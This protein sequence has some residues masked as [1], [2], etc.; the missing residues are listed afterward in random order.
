MRQLLAH[1]AVGKRTKNNP[2]PPFKVAKVKSETTTLQEM[3][4]KLVDKNASSELKFLSLIVDSMSCI[5]DLKTNKAPDDVPLLNFWILGSLL[6][7]NSDAKVCIILWSIDSA[8][9]SSLGTGGGVTL[10]LMWLTSSL[11]GVLAK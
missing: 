7:L 3:I 8:M 6:Y 2:P 9:V 1:Y 4:K 10:R 11:T 5:H